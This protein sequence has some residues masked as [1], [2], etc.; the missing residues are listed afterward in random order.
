[1]NFPVGTIVYFTPFY[2]PNGKSA[3]KNK[4]LIV[5]AH[6]DKDWLVASLPSSVDHVP[7]GVSQDHGC[8]SLPKAMVY[9]YIFEQGRPVTKEGW[10]FPLTTYIYT[11]W[12]EAFD[13]RIFT[14]VYS[15]EGVDYKVIGRL[16]QE[17]YQAVL[18]CALTS[19]DLKGRYRKLLQHVKY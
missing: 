16:V 19:G 15:V 14:E 1:M 17:E 5:L 6:K 12:I 18:D 3:P 4:Y 10:S 11:S 7:N 8:L 13:K 2:F 9:A